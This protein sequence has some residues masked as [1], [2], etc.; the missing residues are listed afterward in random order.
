MTDHYKSF[1]SVYVP[2]ASMSFRVCFNQYPQLGSKQ[3]EKKPQLPFFLGF[4][5]TRSGEILYKSSST[6]LC[7]LPGGGGGGGDGGGELGGGLTSHS[8]S[9]T[10]QGTPFFTCG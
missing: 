5:W 4:A 6:A 8:Q 9:H 2:N 10:T 1:F 3:L 7:A